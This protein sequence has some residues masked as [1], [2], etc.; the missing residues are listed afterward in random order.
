[1]TTETQLNT[2]EVK[3]S[4]GRVIRLK[5]ITGKRRIAF[6]RAVGAKDAGNIGVVS[7]L[8]PTMAVLSIDGNPCPLNALVD[9]EYIYDQLE[10][11]NAFGL[12]DEW[13]LKNSQQKTLNE[14]EER[15]Q[16]KL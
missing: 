2:N 5:E 1:M 3:D 11:G 12:I 13:L 16:K 14:K 15:D 8:W 10:K 6:Y 4:L 9:I 7:E